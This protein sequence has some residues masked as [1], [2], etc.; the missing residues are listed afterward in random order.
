MGNFSSSPLFPP[1]FLPNWGYYKITPNGAPGEKTPGPHQNLLSFPLPTKQPEN[2]SFPPIITTTK[3]AQNHLMYIIIICF[4]FPF[5]DYCSMEFLSRSVGGDGPLVAFGGSDG[6]IRVL[7]MI[8]WKVGCFS[9][10]WSITF[11]SSV[12]FIL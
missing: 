12:S 9:C 3:W 7:S 8:T 5:L 6:V 2:H 4:L 11:R 1:H 10:C